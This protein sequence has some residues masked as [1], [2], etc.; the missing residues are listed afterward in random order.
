MKNWIFSLV[1]FGLTIFLCHAQEKDLKAPN[2]LQE[3]QPGKARS[4]FQQKLKSNSEDAAAMIGLANSM[5]S[6]QYTDSAKILFRKVLTADIKNPFAL[7]GMGLV[8]WMNNDRAG[9]SEYFERARRTDK[10]NPEVYCTIAEGCLDLPKQDT[11]TALIYLRQGLDLHPKYARLHFVTGKLE[12]SKKNYGAAA[13]AYERAIFFDP[14]SALAYRNLGTILFYSRSYRDALAAFNKSVMLNPEQILV[15]KNLGDLYYAVAK[16]ADAERSYL[17]YMEKAEVS[18]EDRERLAFTLFFNKKY[19]EAETLLEQVQQISHDVS[20]LLR[21]RGYID[22][23]TAEYQ[24]GVEQM[25][26]FFRLRDAQKIIASDYSYYARLLQKTGNEV[27]AMDNFRKAIA[28]DPSRAENYEELA[29]LA[30]KNSLHPEAVTCYEK[31]IDLGADKVVTN[32]LIGKEYYFEG[33][34]WRARLDSLMQLQKR[35]GNIYSDNIEAKKS[36]ILFY[37]KADSAFT[38]V[39]KLNSDYAGSFI[40]KGRIQA[41]LD[42]SAITTEAKEAYQNA[43]VILEKADPE[44]NRKSIIECYRYLGSYY[45][46]GYDRLYKSDQKAA[47]EMRSKMIECFTKILKLDPSD[48]QA[49]DVLFKLK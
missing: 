44:K 37:T 40:W 22:Y 34:C 21:I 13:N 12:T 6:V 15:Y 32:F 35:K 23:E 19:R 8:A 49:K 43:L 11:V 38:V 5:L 14:K 36:M 46:L 17:T 7:T 1:I 27:L 26:K 39:T 4:W 18:N 25:T 30:A 33:E 16:Y 2:Y 31:M 9:E 29:K 28:T 45:Y 24:K 47:G 48:A 41:I 20:L 10:T 3:F 42:P